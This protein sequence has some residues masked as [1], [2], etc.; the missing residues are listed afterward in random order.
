L[1]TTNPTWTALSTYLGL[2]GEKLATNC[3]NYCT[4]IPGICCIPCECGTDG[5]H[6]WD[7]M[8]GICQHICLFCQTS[9]Q[10]LNIASNQGCV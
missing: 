2:C 3:L 5:P 6:Q 8:W 4:A 10:L 7:E 1:S 9:R